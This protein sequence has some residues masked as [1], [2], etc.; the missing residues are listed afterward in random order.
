MIKKN[1]KNVTITDFNDTKDVTHK[2]GDSHGNK[3]I[4]HFNNNNKNNKNNKQN[5]NNKNIKDTQEIIQKREFEPKKKDSKDDKSITRGDLVY[6]DLSPVIGSEQGGVRPVLV[7]QNDVGNKFSPTTIV[8]AITSVK[9]KSNLPTHVKV[10]DKNCG[11]PKE[12]VVLMEQIRTIDK[13]RLKDKIG[14]L[15]DELL[16]KIDDALRIS[17]SLE[18]KWEKIF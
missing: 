13:K 7:I 11:L 17:I 3:Q 8:A 18:E 9:N 2:N 15:P 10:G 6:A 5:K 14:R 1:I 16:K 12:S 4:Y